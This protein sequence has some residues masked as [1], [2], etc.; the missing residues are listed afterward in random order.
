ME[1]FNRETNYTYNGGVGVKMATFANPNLKQQNTFQHNVGMN[2]S[3]FKDRIT[4]NLNYYRK[5]T[6]NTLTDIY[7]PASHGFTTVKGN[8]GEVRNEGYDGS[9]SFNVLRSEKFN[10]I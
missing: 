5:L 9:I 7:I 8:V 4:F 1:V 6:D 10:G 3:L 2:L